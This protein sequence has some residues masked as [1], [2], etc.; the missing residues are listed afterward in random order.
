MDVLAAQEENILLKKSKLEK[1][2]EALYQQMEDNSREKVKL[3]EQYSE[4]E[5]EKEVFIN[6]REAFSEKDGEI[7]SAIQKIQEEK[8]KLILSKKPDYEQM[9]QMKKDMDKAGS[10]LEVSMEIVESFVSE[11]R[12]YNQE[13]I[14][15]IW[16]YD[17]EILQILAQ[18]KETMEV[19]I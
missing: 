4:G 5:V 9:K 15:I 13:R 18:E 8:K 11:I 12:V 10:V 19:A 16:K 14:E 1:Q 6:G 17:D 2:Q 3:Y 7:R